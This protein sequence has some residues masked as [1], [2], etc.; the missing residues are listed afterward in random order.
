MKMRW[1]L[2][3]L[4]SIFLLSGCGGN[5]NS[6][7]TQNTD[8]SS[9][10]IS[11]HLIGGAVQV[12]L[13]SLLGTVSTFAGSVQ[14]SSD[15]TGTAARFYGPHGITTDGTNLY[16]T[17]SFNFTVR[18]VV[19]ATGAVTTLAGSA[20]SL[21]S[22][23]GIGTAARFFQPR[24]ITTDGTN[25]YVVDSFNHT[26]RKIEIMTGAV[27][28][29]AGSAGSPGSADGTG[30]AARFR[31]PDGITTDGAN[32]YVADRVNNTIRKIVIE[33]GAVTTLAGSPGSSGTAD[34]QGTTARFNGPQG[35]TT[36]G[37]DLVAEGVA[38][39]TLVTC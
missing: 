29:L 14:G 16:V 1:M 36:D 15:V 8:A 7:T 6:P 24:G 26:I 10:Q 35:I 33:T 17:D 5:S 28:T 2:S 12:N 39:G 34:G 37:T 31:M 3:I 23:D 9:T 11:S 21:G 4:S 32:L 20:G 13:A 30:A 25:L 38:E 18:K 19:I 22:V 27:T